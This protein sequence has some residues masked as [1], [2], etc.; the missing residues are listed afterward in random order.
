MHLQLRTLNS[1][2]DLLNKILRSH[3]TCTNKGQQGQKQQQEQEEQQQKCR[4]EPKGRH[5]SFPFS[6][7]SREGR[8]ERHGGLWWLCGGGIGIDR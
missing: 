7:D 5:G 3:L 1:S 2:A 6:K 4:E 8:Q